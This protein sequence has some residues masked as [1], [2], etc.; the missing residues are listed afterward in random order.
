[1]SRIMSPLRK[2]M[3]Q[4][5]WDSS[6]FYFLPLVLLK[7]KIPLKNWLLIWNEVQY[8]E[9][10]ERA[11]FQMNMVWTVGKLCSEF[12]V[13]IRLQRDIGHI[14]IVALSLVK[15]IID[16]GNSFTRLPPKSPILSNFQ[17]YSYQSCGEM[18]M[19]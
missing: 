11:P 17:V 1:M 9:V 14:N 6:K 5:P 3:Y 2:S 8:M 10:H 19:T 16:L 7:N 12:I 4:I 13:I 15:I 18:P